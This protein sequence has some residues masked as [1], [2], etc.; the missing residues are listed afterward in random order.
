MN[1]RTVMMT[2]YEII[3]IHIMLVLFAKTMELLGMILL[4]RGT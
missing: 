1:G 3:N 4:I 2:I